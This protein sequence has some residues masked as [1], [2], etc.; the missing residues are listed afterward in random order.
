MKK[1]RSYAL[2]LA[3]A[4]TAAACTKEINSPLNEEPHGRLTIN[5]VAGS[6]GNDAAE[7]KAHGE[8]RYDVVWD[9]SDRIAVTDGAQS[10]EFV[11]TEGVGETTGTFEQPESDTKVY[12]GDVTAYYPASVLQADGSLVWPESL[13][14]SGK[15]T[16]VPMIA[17]ST[18]DGSEAE[19]NFRNLGSVLQLVL[20]S[21]DGE[22]ILKS[23][24]IS[25]DNAGMSGPF[26]I[27]DGVA[28]GFEPGRTFT[29]DCTGLIIDATAKMVYIPIPS[30][31]YKNMKL[32]FETSNG[33]VCTMASS[34]ITFNRSAVAK[35]TLA[36][37]GFASKYPDYLSFTALGSS[38]PVGIKSAVPL[39]YRPDSF[40][41]E[42]C[43]DLEADKWTSFTLDGSKDGVQ[44]IATISDGQTIFLRVKKARTSLGKENAQWV[45]DFGNDSN[46]VVA[47]GN[48]MSLLDPEVKST[49]AGDYA[50]KNLFRDA[51]QLVS[52]PKL[53]ARTLGVGCYSNMFNG[54]TN[55]TE[56]PDLPAAY[57][58]KYCYEYMFRNTGLVTTASMHAS[59]LADYCCQFMYEVCR[60]LIS[61]Y[62]LT[63]TTLAK[64]CYYT[65]FSECTSL[66]DAPDL[67]SLSLAYR[68]YSNMFYQCSSLKT[69]PALPATTLADECY[70]SMFESC[71]SLVDAPEL[72]ATVMT[73]GC[74]SCMFEDCASLV[75]APDLPSTNLANMCYFR[76]FKDCISLRKA[77]YLPATTLPDMCY[78][79]MFYRCTSLKTVSVGFTKWGTSDKPT[80][81]WL[82]QVSSSGTFYCSST[83]EGKY[84]DNYI[85]NGW[86]VFTD[87]AP[88]KLGD[89]YWSNDVEGM[90]VGDINVGGKQKKLI[91]A[92]RNLGAASMY[93]K[94]LSYSRAQLDA[95]SLPAGWSVPTS[96]DIDVLLDGRAFYD[97]FNDGTSCSIGGKW[98]YIPYTHHV[99]VTVQDSDKKVDMDEA[100]LW[101]S[102]E[103]FDYYWFRSD[104][105]HGGADLDTSSNYLRLVKYL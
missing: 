3:V 33:F 77:P 56:A 100:R 2:L 52:A 57:L 97:E 18:V 7:T 8:Y 98:Y 58:A 96:A 103:K 84:G 76:M 12:S 83:L 47:A 39:N 64:S 29:L 42:Y 13:T 55:L 59:T 21:T 82:S 49:T 94:G 51:V 101:I 65:M 32:R 68:C 73:S 16:G 72:S 11:L 14:W 74:Y 5:A 79:Y 104:N 6:L 15:L 71:T 40:D 36:L 38:V 85:P 25:A 63:A 37:G 70:T 69:A 66:T 61:A 23:I 41:L 26:T 1:I 24:T 50:F 102:D 93:E 75:N 89:L 53:P 90:Y 80:Y 43:L 9:A 87:Q 105:K 4:V 60:S 27:S 99:Q 19:F 45:F 92:T 22:K 31:T 67:P 28:T 81:E 95:L 34:E 30:A 78:M 91:F 44:Q 20:T 88:T 54:C 62:P 10:S 86:T 17:S 46:R 48:I 35:V